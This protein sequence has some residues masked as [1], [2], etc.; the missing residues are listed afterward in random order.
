MKFG[1]QIVRFDWPGSP[2]NIGSKLA[3][4]GQT[5]E[6]AGFDSIWV[7][8]HFFQMDM[9]DMGLKPEEPMLDGYTALSYLA[10]VTERARLG[11]MVTGVNYRHPGHLLKIVSNLDVLSGG[12]ANLG[13][14]AGWYEREAHGLGFPFPPLKERFERLEET[15]QIMKQVWSGDISA[16]QGKH[17]HLAEPMNNP[18]PLSKPHPPILIGGAGEK[19][20]LRL[21]AQYADACNLFAF[22]GNEEL[23]CKLDVLKRHCDDVGRDYAEIEKTALGF[24]MLGE[25][26]MSP[27]DV[28]GMCRGL[29]EVG[30]DSFIFSLGNVHDLAPIEVIGREVIPAV[31]EF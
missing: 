18:Q 12:R 2:A 10:A 21:V 7:M 30:F 26:G 9:P 3:E 15:L 14:G 22:M 16:Y 19:K 6:S 29:A 1:L 8:D 27:S 4:I 17:Y 20:T 5:A 23:A 31:A 24:V 13:I 28:I 25:G 11:T